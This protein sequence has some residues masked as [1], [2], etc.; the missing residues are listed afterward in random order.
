[1]SDKVRGT[2]AIAVGVFA[3]IQGYTLYRHAQVDWRLWVEVLAG[4]LLIVIGI[5][6]ILR[7][8]YDPMSDLLK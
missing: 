2:I 7:K 6:R 5:W 4:L 1:M 3:L 8:P